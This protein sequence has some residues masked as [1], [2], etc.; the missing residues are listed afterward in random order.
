[1]VSSCLKIDRQI[2]CDYI[3]YLSPRMIQGAGVM[4]WQLFRWVLDAPKYR[5]MN[6]LWTWPAADQCKPSNWMCSNW[7]SPDAGKGHMRYKE[8]IFITEMSGSSQMKQPLRNVFL[9]H[10]Y[11]NSKKI[12]KVEHYINRWCDA[13]PKVCHIANYEIAAAV[14]MLVRELKYANLEPPW[15]VINVNAMKVKSFYI[16]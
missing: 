7:K 9:E 5:T 6:E 1:M 14:T 4:H 11:N 3:R 8:Y 2:I 16:I 13:G 10:S 12:L 15:D